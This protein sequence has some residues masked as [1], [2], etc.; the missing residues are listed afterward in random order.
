MLD[1]LIVNA[2]EKFVGI[3]SGVGL[4]LG[5]DPS[6]HFRYDE[7]IRPDQRQK[8]SRSAQCLF[9]H[10]HKSPPQTV[11]FGLRPPPHK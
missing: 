1:L 3:D 11:A 4:P 6:Q 9:W 8:D 5:A 7:S 10:L 2:G